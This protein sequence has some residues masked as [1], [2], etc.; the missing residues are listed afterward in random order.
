MKS[1]KKSWSACWTR[2]SSSTL[3]L[4]VIPL[5]VISGFVSV[6]GPKSSNWVS[7]SNYTAWN[8][9]S[10]SAA[11]GDL[12]GISVISTPNDDGVLG[13]RSN[14]VVMDSTNNVEEAILAAYESPLNRSSSP[15]TV[16]EADDLISQSSHQE[17]VRTTLSLIYSHKFTYV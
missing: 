8:S 3:L 9:S 16:I 1:N 6:L 2:A 15:L 12:K 4:L 11:A 5:V 7:M 14:L 17:R 13:L 10:S